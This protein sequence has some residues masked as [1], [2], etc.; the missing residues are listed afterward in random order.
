M[1]SFF[2]AT[3]FALFSILCCCRKHVFF[4]MVANRK[5]QA[6]PEHIPHQGT[7][8]IADK[9]Q[10]NTC[11]RQNTNRHPNILEDVEGNHT[12]DTYTNI[13]I[14]IILRFHSNLGNMINQQEKQT[15]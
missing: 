4:I 15:N 7:S 1:A 12:D 2:A 3:H 8:S 13:R 11:N 9:R 6:K 10:W 5:N 14:K